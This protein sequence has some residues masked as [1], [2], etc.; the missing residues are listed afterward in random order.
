MDIGGRTGTWRLKVCS[1]LQNEKSFI[2]KS[3]SMALLFV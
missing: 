1:A 2:L 3:G